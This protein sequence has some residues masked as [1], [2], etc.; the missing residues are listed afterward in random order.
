MESK[1]DS[2]EVAHQLTVGLVSHA[3]SLSGK[4]R[5]RLPAIPE[6]L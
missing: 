5:L 1:D 4:L 6:F 2:M 3:V